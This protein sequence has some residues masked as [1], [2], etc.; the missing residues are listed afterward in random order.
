MTQPPIV[1]AAGVL[2]MTR[3]EPHRFLLMKHT[4]RWDLPKGH[5]EA[6]ESAAETALREMHEETGIHPRHVTLDTEFRFR[7]V[8]SVRYP[9]QPDREFEKRL[10]IFLGWVEQVHEV[11]CSEHGDC[12]WFAWDPP[13]Q[14]QAQ[15]IDPLLAAVQQYL[16]VA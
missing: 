3:P 15:A 16:G 1:Y 4:D 13:H 9:D 14:V 11:Q 5:A 2:L 7:S 6:G 12:R 8:Y 10:T